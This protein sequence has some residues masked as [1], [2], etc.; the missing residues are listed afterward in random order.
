M[1]ITAVRPKG[2]I[3]NADIVKDNDGNLYEDRDALVL[4]IYEYPNNFGITDE[5][6]RV[7]LGGNWHAGQT[8]AQVRNE[9]DVIVWTVC[10]DPDDTYCGSG[11]IYEGQYW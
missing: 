11:G 7:A 2:R 9:S 1:Y 4:E 3:Y 8:E 6:A 10:E 5:I